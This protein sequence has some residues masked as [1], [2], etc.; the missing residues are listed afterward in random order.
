MSYYAVTHLTSFS[1]SDTITDSVMEVRMQ[2]RSDE[3]QS[4][5]RFEL[6][7]SPK[8]RSFSH[9]DYLGNIIHQFDIPGR[10]RRLAVR[11]ESIVETKPFAPLPDSLP[12]F[13]WTQIAD[14][15]DDRDLFDMILPST[16]VRPSG[17][18]NEFI[19]EKGI[20]KGDD[21]LAT[22]I[23]LNRTIYS[24]LAY[25]ANVT[26]VDSPIEHAL[27]E[28]K[29][30]CQDFTHIMLTVA[31]GMGI[32]S[33]Y[34]SGYLFY[35]ADRPERSADDES[36]A[37]MEA[38]LPGL[39]W[40]GFD[41]TNNLICGER[42]IRVAVGRDYED[43]PPTKGVFLGDADSKLDVSVKVS[44]LEEL[45]V[46]GQQHAPEIALPQFELL[47]YHQQQQQQ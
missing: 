38:W 24:S 26:Q 40:V 2:P 18:L 22:L 39:G 21:P 32:P 6:K 41:P 25:E 45:P 42:H 16:F 31:R 46:D 44:R 10:H 1:Y 30:V 7:I 9:R 34:V 28:G 36:H 20:V 19:A 14:A 47:Q 27:V 13:A 33:R 3:F 8:A 17:M 29:G 15:L 4:C 43:V 11:A 12:A 35:R 5:I 37:W 23:A